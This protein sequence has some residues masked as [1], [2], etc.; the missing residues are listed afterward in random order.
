MAID[1]PTRR[2]DD[3][4]FHHWREHVNERLDSQDRLLREIRDAL[5]ASKMGLLAIR[6]LIL[7][8]AGIAAIWGAFQHSGR[9]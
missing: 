2:L 8:G 4:D 1:R 9:L 7:V 5:G 3:A 6:W